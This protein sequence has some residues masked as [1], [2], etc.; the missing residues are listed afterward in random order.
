MKKGFLKNKE[1]IVV[2]VKTAGVAVLTA[3]TLFAFGFSAVSGINDSKLQKQQAELIQREEQVI[4]DIK[5][6]ENFL[7]WFENKVTVANSALQ[8]EI[9]TQ[10]QHDKVIADF[11]SDEY[12]KNNIDRFDFVT[13]AQKSTIAEVGVAQKEVLEQQNKAELNTIAS[14]GGG[15]LGS[16][17]CASL[18]SDLY[19]KNKWLK[20][21]RK[22]AQEEHAQ[23]EQEEQD[24]ELEFEN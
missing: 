14:L 18:Y 8:E 22:K 1:K 16:V 10:E 2:A 4:N 20:I 5:I 13:E 17:A 12:L 3:G 15:L 11:A 23:E 7:S 19:K 6:S 21:L 9:I 24:E